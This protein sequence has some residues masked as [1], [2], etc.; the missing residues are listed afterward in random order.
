[1]GTNKT[2]RLSSWLSQLYGSRKVGL[3]L[4]S[5]ASAAAESENTVLKTARDGHQVICEDNPREPRRDDATILTLGD[6]KRLLDG[7]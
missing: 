2:I 5:D 6:L 7:A 3:T 1:M 4:S